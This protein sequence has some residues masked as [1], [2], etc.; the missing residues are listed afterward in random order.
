MK[1]A[2]SMTVCLMLLVSVLFGCTAPATEAPA[3]EAPATEAA[4]AAAADA[5]PAVDTEAAPTY[6]DTSEMVIGLSPGASGSYWGTTLAA[7]CEKVAQAYIDAG[8][9]K[10]FKIVNN[11]TN[12]DAVE[13][14]SIIR[15]FINDP[16]V[17]IIMFNPVGP[18][19]MYGVMEEAVAAG[20]LVV[21]YDCEIETPDGVYCVSVDHY[22][23]GTKIAE[24]VCSTI[25]SGN[26]IQIY[27]GE[28]HPANIERV[29]ATHD[30][31]AKYPNIE[32][33]ADQTGYWSPTKAYDVA[34][35]ILGSGVQVDGLITQDDMSG[36]ILQACIDLGKL[37][38]AMFCESTYS[39]VV[40]WKQLRDQGADIKFCSQPNPPGIAATALRIALYLAEGRT[41]KDGVL[42]GEYGKTFNYE[43][44]QWWTDETFDDLWEIMKDKSA[45]YLINEYLTDEE[46]AALFN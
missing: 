14:A 34:T 15:D 45:D 5:A 44:T 7:E 9:L 17:D 26:A 8:R 33:V 42:S 30:V 19:D 40:L 23:W 46:A 24:F 13:Q 29:R 25:G 21:V 41:F 28:T 22:K 3:T 27:G 37:P 43:V 1:K 39:A 18:T 20:K 16:E 36:S 38:K 32:L 4:P 11:V 2:L 35:Q 10:G 6:N 31:L 12:Y